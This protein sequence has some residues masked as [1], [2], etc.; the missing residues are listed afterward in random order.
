M[1]LFRKKDINNAPASDGGLRRCLSPLDLTFLGVGAIIGAGIFILTGIVAA[2]Q[3]GPAIVFS[4][5]L[6]GLAC[7]FTALSYAE[8]AAA[9]GGCGSAYGYAY[10]GFGE[11]IGWIVGWDLLLEYAVSVSTVAVGW[12]EYFNELLLAMHLHIPSNFIHS[13]LSGGYFN[14]LAFTITVLLAGVLA[15]GA[16]SSAR[17]NNIMVTIKLLVIL[18]FIVYRFF[19]VVGCFFMLKIGDDGLMFFCGLFW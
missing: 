6:A 16:K 17:M 12:S 8:L 2:T 5:V 19:D 10:A 4:Y 14:A 7:A 18:L 15:L 9:I 13:P 11:I 3:T 1:D